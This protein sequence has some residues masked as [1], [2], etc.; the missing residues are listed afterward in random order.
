M[1]WDTAPK[2]IGELLRV[3]IEWRVWAC[4]R[5]KCYGGPCEARS[6]PKP[7][8]RRVVGKV[9]GGNGDC[10]RGQQRQKRQNKQAD[11]A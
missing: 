11:R 9:S 2:P 5:G 1:V 8:M 10:T 7:A 6:A 4:A 3:C